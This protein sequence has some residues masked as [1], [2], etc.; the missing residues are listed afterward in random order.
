MQ[1][2]FNN[3]AN[4][5]AQLQDVRKRL[6][7]QQQEMIKRAT[8]SSYTRDMRVMRM[9]AN[10]QGPQPRCEQMQVLQGTLRAI[11]RPAVQQ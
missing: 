11:R 10:A 7:G 2:C 8:R 4:R 9:T 3:A 5:A 1:V 6:F